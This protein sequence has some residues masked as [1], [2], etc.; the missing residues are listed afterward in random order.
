MMRMARPF[1]NPNHYSASVAMGSLV[2]LGLALALLAGAT[3]RLDRLGVKTALL[4]RD[5]T[6]P[7]VLAAGVLACLGVVGVVISQSRGGLLALACGLAFLIA[8]RW[9]KGWIAVAV[10]A[11][12]LTGLLAGI[13]T[14]PGANKSAFATPSLAASG[15]DP[16]ALMRIDAWGKTL[17]I[18]L[19]YPVAGTGLGTFEWAF[20]GYQRQGESLA[21]R[22]AHN[23]YVQVLSETGII[24]AALLA[25]ALGVFLLRILVPALRGVDGEPRWTTIG[26]AAAVF[27]L[28]VHSTLDFNL[29][30]P[31]NA[32]QFAV[33]LGILA[34]AAL[35]DAP[36]PAAAQPEAT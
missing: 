34:A 17:R 14:M 2:A 30:I 12:V 36:A 15:M 13:P 28:I 11:V 31:A 35:D 19:D 29:Q 5:W 3:G 33:L 10:V 20:S 6:L 24:G 21:L 18:F 4:D 8:A 27:A 7:R 16:S 26:T 25:W 9:L 22:Q 32:A 1:I 23:D